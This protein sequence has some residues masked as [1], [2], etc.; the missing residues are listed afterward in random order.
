[1]VPPEAPS[2]LVLDEE[3]VPDEL[4][5]VEPVEDESCV[6]DEPSPLPPV[7]DVYTVSGGEVPS[8]TSDGLMAFPV[9]V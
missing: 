8:L 2:E 1:M 5:P 6:E 9:D 3:P 7:E 4:P